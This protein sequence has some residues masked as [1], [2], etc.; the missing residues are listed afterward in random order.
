MNCCRITSYNVCYTKLLR[1]FFDPVIIEP[2]FAD[3]GAGFDVA[4]DFLQPVD[5][6][7]A[8]IVGQFMSSCNLATGTP[9]Q[10]PLQA[11]PYRIQLYRDNLSGDA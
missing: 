1:G 5:Q 10:N 11:G 7:D 6:A 8:F 4:A 3:G 9:G 2:H